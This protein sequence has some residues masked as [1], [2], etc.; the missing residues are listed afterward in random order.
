MYM[1]RL[2]HNPEV[3]EVFAE[4]AIG[5]DSDYIDDSMTL[6]D[7]FNNF[8]IPQILETFQETVEQHHIERDRPAQ[9]SLLA[10]MIEE[11]DD[12]CEYTFKGIAQWLSDTLEDETVPYDVTQTAYEHKHNALRLDYIDPRSHYDNFRPYRKSRIVRNIFASTH[13][14]RVQTMQDTG[15]IRHQFRHERERRR[16]YGGGY[17]PLST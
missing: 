3:Y 6:I 12:Y 10:T 2:T 5:Y 1:T 8:A 14:R 16:R 15:Y 4:W 13:R 7:V 9:L 11:F 17:I